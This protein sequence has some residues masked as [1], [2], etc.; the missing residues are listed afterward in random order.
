MALRMLRYEGDEI[1]RKKSKV[2][3]NITNKIIMLL[4]D[5]AETMYEK[6]GVGLAAPQ[7]GVLRR[8]I[9]IDSGEGLEEYINP[10]IIEYSGTQKGR[11]ACLS[12]PGKNGLVERPE[13][14]K[15]KAQDRDGNEIIVEATE[16]KA[17]IF[18]HE[19]DHLEGIIY[20]DKVIEEEEDIEKF[21]EEE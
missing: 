16:N 17:V 14:V 5:M 18:C 8:I 19:I 20:T 2:V 6:E 12:L 21:I 10:E 4:E 15:V 11:E 3:K 9:V 13:Y 7:V 1:L